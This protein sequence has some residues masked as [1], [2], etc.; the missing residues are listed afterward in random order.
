MS[1]GGLHPATPIAGAFGGETLGDF[2]AWGYSNILTNNLRGVFA[3]FLVAT[4]L[5]ETRGTRTEWDAF[6]VLYRSA[7]V[8]G[9]AKI[10]VKSSAY[11]QSWEQEKPSAISWG[12][13][14]R[15]AFDPKTNDWTP[16]KARHADLYVFCVYT[17]REDRDPA[18]VL[19]L[20]R[21]EFYVVPTGVIDEELGNQ[22]TVGLGRIKALTDSVGYSHL[23]ERVD[24]A[25][26]NK[27]SGES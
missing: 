27:K 11:L 24:E 23:R 1:K 8:D 21:W 20:G 12:L 10:E 18:K 3:E 19:D 6:D 15:Y 13:G 25:L 7:G 9:G 17:E 22:K 4:A 5:G 26:A 2:W 16:E 14:E